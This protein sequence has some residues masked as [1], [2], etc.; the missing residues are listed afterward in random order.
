[1]DKFCPHPLRSENFAGSVRAD[2]E[3]KQSIL[4]ARKYGEKMG[5]R[6]GKKETMRV[7][8]WYLF[9]SVS[10]Q[11]MRFD[12][13]RVEL[14]FWW[15]PLINPG[16]PMPDHAWSFADGFGQV[17][18][19]VQRCFRIWGPK[20][21]QDW[22]WFTNE[23]QRIVFGKYT[24]LKLGWLWQVSRELIKAVE[25][26]RKEL[27]TACEPLKVK[28]SKKSKEWWLGGILKCDWLLNFW[29]GWEWLKMT[30]IKF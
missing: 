16:K 3:S 22:K 14:F 5:K 12:N 27:E 20:V 29:C 7:L 13:F 28:K 23:M 18:G 10:F 1:M 21:F 25:D 4:E 19:G 30:P 6:W 24:T 9:K 11:H 2:V 8:F 15:Y 17:S 26:A